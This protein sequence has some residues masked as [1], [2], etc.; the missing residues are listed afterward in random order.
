MNGVLTLTQGL[1]NTTATKILTLNNTAS[2]TIG[3]ATSFVNGPLACNMSNLGTSTLNLPIGKGLD[4][5]PAVLSPTQ[6]T[7][8]SY[9]YT[10]E[11]F[12]SSALALGWALPITI[13]NVSTV[14]FMDINR[15]VTL[16][17]APASSTDLTS[18]V[19]RMYYN[20]GAVNG[21]G[22]SVNDYVNLTI[23]KAPVAGS[24]WTDISGTATANGTGSILSGAFTSFS[25]FVLANKHLGNNALPIEL[26][27]FTAKE[28]K[29]VVDLN[30][31]TASEI[32]NDYF[33]IE[34]T[35]NGTDFEL[36]GTQ[37]GAGNST[38]KITYSMIDNKPLM[39]ISYYRLS[40]T[41]FN[42][43]THSFNPVAV[44]FNPPFNFSVYPNPS[45]GDNLFLSL[46]GDISNKEI[47]V[48]LYN[49]TGQL[50]Y[51][52]VI[53]TG[54]SNNLLE[55]IDPANKL[56]AGVYLIVASSDNA[57]YKQKI[58]IQ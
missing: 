5:R 9:T 48:V 18:A 33:S 3:N 10:A 52:K 19:V 53:L 24:T 15:T 41:D 55:A 30:W 4:W 22:D 40:Q 16:T 26:L 31:V 2:T 58:I 39:G 42:G 11:L 14:H 12:D 28:N 38:E 36:I 46:S 54:Q 27:S 32:N 43:L 8:I 20:T 21:N 57:I 7:G 17:T 49:E 13:D 25:R 35:R 1:I 34:R 44:D 37:K 45:N 6:S 47:L 23:A 51:S 29:N 56:P 50:T